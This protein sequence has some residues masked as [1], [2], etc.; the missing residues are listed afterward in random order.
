MVPLLFF[1]ILLG[2]QTIFAQGNI[3]L[4]K[5]ILV[6]FS[7]EAN[8]PIQVLFSS[9]FRKE[10]NRRSFYPHDVNYE[11]LDLARFRDKDF[12]NNL[13]K[14]LDKKYSI[15]PPDVVIVYLPHAA[16]FVTEYKL[17]PGIPKIYITPQLPPSSKVQFH[18]D[19]VSGSFGLDFKGNI[20]HG[21]ELFPDTNKIFVI[22][23]GGVSDKGFENAFKKSSEEFKNQIT[24]EYIRGLEV[25]HLLSRVEDLP[26][27]SL[28]YYLTYSEDSSG[29][30]YHSD[31]IAEQL[32][33]KA[34]TP[35]FGF[36]DLLVINTG[37][38]GGRVISVESIATWTAE[39]TWRVLKGEDIK[40]IKD[41]E[42]DHKYLYNWPKLKKWGLDVK[43]L[44]S[45]SVVLHR[46]YTFFELYKWQVLGGI[47]A[48][49]LEL[50]L[51]FVLFANI[52]KRKQA[53]ENLRES[54]EKY[55]QLFEIAQEGI[56]VIDVDS[57]TTM[58]NPSMAR[59]LGYPVEEM[60]G[61]HLFYFMDDHGKTV[62]ENNL[63]RRKEG[64]QEQHDFELIHENGTR[65]FTTMETAP[66]VNDQGDYVGAIAGVIDI[67]KRKQA[68]KKL[69]KNQYY[70][71]KAQEIG[72]IGTWELD[73]Q[74]NILT[75]TEQNY[76]I[77]GVPLGTEMTY[78]LFLD[79]VHP[80][81][82]DYV[83]E[84]WNV[85]LEKEPYDIEHRLIVDDKVK[86]VREKADIEFDSQGKPLVAIGFTQDITDFKQAEEQIKSSLKEKETL[87]HEIHHR[88]KNNMQVINSLLKLQS[89]NIED[90]RIKDIL[91]D[92]QS[93]V[94]A[95]SAVHETLHGSEKLS[96]IDLKTYLTKITTSVF[97]TYSTDHQKVKLNSNVENSPISLNQANPLG[98]IINELISN[99]LKYAFPGEKNGEINVDVKKFDKEL[100]LIVKDN[101]IGMPNDFD[102]KNSSTLGLKLVRTLVEKQLDGSID[103]ENKNGTKAI[104]KFN[105]ET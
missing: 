104:I 25:E 49:I 50:L 78:E 37:I 86:W 53:G 98:L 56:W 15:Y 7:L 105:I 69:V 23:G 13:K 41:T 1:F 31:K 74:K 72:I 58:V 79:R 64:I 90:N 18:S 61:K 91:K 38:L 28:I 76:K 35:V 67:T 5:K 71:S 73:I 70:L 11:N 32:G 82:R 22:R 27:Q 20:E 99:S 2:N 14:L 89:N 3:P 8:R 85:G 21:L 55:R 57:N 36:M 92:S 97:Q 59:L 39:V 42:F 63:K 96:E 77:F 9:S 80:D 54:E 26:E 95:M 30:R 29:R 51:I 94:Y 102:W 88:V 100:E 4:G 10:M 43:S 6:L 52:N 87:L 75:W 66:I 44:P 40:S 62:A 19:S 81:D 45:N 17:F 68:E 12:K 65:I 47:L 33:Q 34:N 93:R 46:K 101:G 84:K 48:L 103:M 60:I 83:N 24:F 16:R